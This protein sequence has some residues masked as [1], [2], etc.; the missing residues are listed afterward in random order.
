MIPGIVRQ[1]P[2]PS[3]PFRVRAAGLR[4]HPAAG[5]GPIPALAFGMAGGHIARGDGRRRV[6]YRWT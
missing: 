3:A 5:F 2:K 6:S 1:C 4:G